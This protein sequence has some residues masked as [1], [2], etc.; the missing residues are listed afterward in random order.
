MA[1]SQRKICTA[2][3]SVLLIFGWKG[4]RTAKC[5]SANEERHQDKSN[6][7]LHDFREDGGKVKAPV[8]AAV[9]HG[10]LFVEW[11][12]LMEFPQFRQIGVAKANTGEYDD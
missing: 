9:V 8:V 6:D 5:A 2:T 12:D 3:K 11:R 10:I 7:T 1:W 4:L